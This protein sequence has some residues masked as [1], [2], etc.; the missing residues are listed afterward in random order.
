MTKSYASYFIRMPDDESAAFEEWRARQVPV[1]S[2]N[3]AV[4]EAIR[5]MIAKPVERS[6]IDDLMK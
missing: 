1:P 2:K 4:R 5:Q 6:S 3:E